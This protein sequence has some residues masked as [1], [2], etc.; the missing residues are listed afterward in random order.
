MS[1]SKKVI[2][3][4]SD[5]FK[6]NNLAFFDSIFFMPNKLPDYSI[7][8]VTARIDLTSLTCMLITDKPEYLPFQLQDNLQ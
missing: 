4:I 8:A 7:H 1:K 5:F 3:I 2:L 6:I